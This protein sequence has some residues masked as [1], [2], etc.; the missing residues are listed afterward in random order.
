MAESPRGG[1]NSTGY[2]PASGRW[3][4]LQFDGDERKFEQWEFRFLGYMLL[5]KLK[6]TVLPPTEDE[7]AEDPE[8]QELAF[9]EMIQFLD[10]KSLGIV[11]RDA[12]D[13]GRKAL[14][15][16]REHYAGSSKPRIIS[17]YTELTNLKKNPK[18]SVTDYVIRTEKVATALRAA[19]EVIN[20]GLLIAMVLKGLPE[21]YSSFVVVTTQN[22]TQQA[23]FSKFKTALRS[24]E[25]TEQ[26]RMGNEHIMKSRLGQNGS[27]SGGTGAFGKKK[28]RCLWWKF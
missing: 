8:K 10:D 1:G 3:T 28:W 14:K 13:N 6:S 2:G 7:T 15:L 21:E 17:M 25:D 11:M 16:L 5:S 18:E 20:D 24:F 27:H 4:R 23:D 26:S 12:K 9:A 19:G 22:E